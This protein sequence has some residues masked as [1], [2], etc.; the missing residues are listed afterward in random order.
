MLLFK[1]K[2]GLLPRNIQFLFTLNTNEKYCKRQCDYFKVKFA[3]TSIKSSCVSISGVKLWNSL[4]TNILF[5]NSLC[6]LKMLK[7]Y[8]LSQ[9]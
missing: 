4:C 6:V 9:Y 1:A 3:R 5:Y 8:H 7:D 2:R